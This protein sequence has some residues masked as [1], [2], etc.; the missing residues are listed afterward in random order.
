M[1]NINIHDAKTNL[2]KYLKN[3]EKGETLILCKRNVAIAE[4]RPILKQNHKKRPFGLAK[5]EIKLS[6]DC[7]DTLPDELVDSFYNS[8]LPE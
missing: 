8:T 6:D 7:F 4:I 3:I 2:S 5:G 1:L